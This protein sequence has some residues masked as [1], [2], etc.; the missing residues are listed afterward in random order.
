MEISRELMIGCSSLAHV[1]ESIHNQEK[2]R[3]DSFRGRG[4]LAAGRTFVE[5]RQSCKEGLVYFLCQC[6]KHLFNKGCPR[7]MQGPA[8]RGTAELYHLEQTLLEWGKM[9]C[10]QEV[11]QE[12]GL[13]T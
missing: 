10:G 6:L 4:N 2:S 11:L 9:K 3:K 5:S 7:Q 12:Q 1:T 13:L 8:D